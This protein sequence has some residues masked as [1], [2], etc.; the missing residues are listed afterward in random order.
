MSGHPTP[1]RIVDAGCGVINSENR[2]FRAEDT[3]IVD[4]I[5]RE[6]IGSSERLRG[7]DNLERIV[8]CVNACGGISGQL[9][10]H[11]PVVPASR[12]SSAINLCQELLELVTLALPYIE[13][14]VGDPLYKQDGVKQLAS[15]LHAA[16]SYGMKGVEP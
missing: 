11:G 3:C 16:A 7:E 5:G 13:T 2:K 9:L 6:V 4:A 12:Y 10:S 14:A 8:A 1:W 15:K